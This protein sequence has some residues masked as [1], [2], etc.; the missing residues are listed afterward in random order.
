[1]GDPGRCAGGVHD[2][3]DPDQRHA[4]QKREKAAFQLGQRNRIVPQAELDQYRRGRDRCDPADGV[5]DRFDVLVI[6]EPQRRLRDDGRSRDHGDRPD[7]WLGGQSICRQKG[8]KA[9][10]SD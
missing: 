9:P 4:A 10:S 5:H 3:P 8:R 1:M 7:R 6:P 2:Q